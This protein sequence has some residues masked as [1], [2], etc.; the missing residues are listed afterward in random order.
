MSWWHPLDAPASRPVNNAADI[1][2]KPS[3]TSP[4][5]HH[6]Y[7]HAG[8]AQIPIG[9]KPPPVPYRATAGAR[10]VPK[11]VASRVSD[12]EDHSTDDEEEDDEDEDETTTT[13]RDKN[14]WTTA[15]CIKRKWTVSQCPLAVQ[16]QFRY[17]CFGIL[18]LQLLFTASMVYLLNLE[19]IG[20][21]TIKENIWIPI[22]NIILVIII[23]I[24]LWAKWFQQAR[25]SHQVFG[26]VM[27]TLLLTF[28]VFV[29]QVYFD[30]KVLL[31]GLVL[32]GSLIFVFALLSLQSKVG[33]G[34]WS[35]IAIA[36]VGLLILSYF[37][38]YMP[39]TAF[40]YHPLD[41]WESKP[42]GLLS[43]FFTIAFAFLVV[44]TLIF[45]L[46]KQEE[47]LRPD[48]YL[49]SVYQLYLKSLIVLAMSVLN[50][51]APTP[52]TGNVSSTLSR[53]AAG[54]TVRAAVEHVGVVG[55]VGHFV[56][57]KL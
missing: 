19:Q 38:L 5:L 13:S 8:T 28:T 21:K 12:E 41:N 42:I 29:V 27:T 36:I 11:T 18:S 16:A 4:L 31:E 20:F 34:K 43:T 6:L 33:I 35:T 52:S 15:Q 54:A 46:R 10:P 45:F 53:N 50:M 55:A 3:S 47:S 14:T 2:N 44:I 51:V 7:H 17:R 24:I 49:Y 57:P 37:V 56:T 40:W 39:Y 30:T 23:A 32:A 25:F 48:E 9:Y 22:T 26:L 1:P